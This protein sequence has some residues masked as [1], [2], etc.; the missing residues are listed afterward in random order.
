MGMSQMLQRGKIK[1]NKEQFELIFQTY[2]WKKR[3]FGYRCSNNEETQREIIATAIEN[4]EVN[5]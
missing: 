5:V 4:L 2:W 1:M 3:S